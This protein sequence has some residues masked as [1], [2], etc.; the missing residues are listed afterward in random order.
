MDIA[1][2]NTDWEKEFPG[3]IFLATSRVDESAAYINVAGHH[4]SKVSPK[5]GHIVWT[6]PAPSRD[7]IG[8]IEESHRVLYAAC[9]SALFAVD[10]SSGKIKWSTPCRDALS[11]Q[12][13]RLTGDAIFTIC[14]ESPP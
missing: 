8:W 12:P 3:R 7:E 13:P 14:G 9:D 5:D 1:T 11:M 4:I 6:L 2:G 10:A